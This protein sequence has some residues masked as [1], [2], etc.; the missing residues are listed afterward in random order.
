[1]HAVWVE[2]A[3][4]LHHNRSDQWG[5]LHMVWAWQVPNRAGSHRRD[6]LHMVCC[7]KVPERVRSNLSWPF[8]IPSF[9][10]LY[11]S[12]LSHFPFLTYSFHV[13]LSHTQ[14]QL[15]FFFHTHK[16]NSFLLSLFVSP[17]LYP[18]FIPPSMSLTHYLFLSISFSSSLHCFLSLCGTVTDH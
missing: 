11:L 4:F 16:L 5:Q 13:Y 14:T 10:R 2:L 8:K 9:S 18:S 1:M 6:Q 17:S 12:I 7:W 15:L 3:L